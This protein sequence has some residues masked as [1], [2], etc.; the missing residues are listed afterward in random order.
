MATP[1]EFNVSKSGAATYTIPIQIPPGTAGMEPKLSLAY[2]SQSGNG[3]LGVGWSLAGLSTITRCPQTIAQDGLSRAVRYVPDDRFCLDGQRLIAIS[4]AYGANGTEYRTERDSFAKIVSFGS[5]GSGPASFT[6]WTKSGQVMDYGATDDSR[7]EAQGKA[8]VKVWAL[9]KVRDTKGNYFTVSYVEDNANGNYYPQSINYTGNTAAGVAPVNSVQFQYEGRPDIFP[10][11]QAG[12]LAQMT[13]RM[14]R[15]VTYANGVRVKDYVLSYESS[16]AASPSQGSR[17]TK[18]QECL[19]APSTTCFNSIDLAWDAA[20]SQLF[21][22]ATQNVGWGFGSP[23]S[24]G[25]TLVVGDFNGDGKSD[26]AYI[27]G[28]PSNAHVALSN[29]DGTFTTVQ[30]DMG[31]GFGT[32]PS[33]GFT[34]VVGDFNGDGKTDWAFVGGSPSNVHVALSNGDGTFTKVQQSLGWGFGTP[35]SAQFTLVA[36]DFNG[37][38]KT[39]FAFIG[40]NPSNAHVAL[41]NGDGTFTT[42]Q[43][44]MGWSF[45]APP[46][47]GYTLVVGDFN[48]DGKT[49]WAFVGGSPSNV[50]VALSNGDGTFTKV[51]QSL[52][53]GF[54]TPPSAQFTLV[55]GDFNGDGKTDFAFIGASPS[56]AH[57]AISTGD[58][59]FR[60]S[61]QQLFG[62]S[63][64]SP[65]SA[66]FD[67][68]TGDFNG[69]GKTDFAFVGASPTSKA[70][71]ILSAGNGAFRSGGEQLLLGWYFGT[72]PSKTYDLVTGDFNGDGKNDFLYISGSTVY[73]SLSTGGSDRLQQ[74][75]RN[76][77]GADVS[78]SYK[79]LTDSTVYTKDTNASR[80]VVDLQIP[81]YVVSSVAS[82]NGIGGTLTTNY[83]YGG[84]K[85]EAGTGR[86][87]LGFR[88]MRAT[89][90]DTG[91]ATYT[92]YR[93]DWPYTGMPALLKK[94]LPGSGN[95]GVLSQVSNSFGCL[96]PTDGSNCVVLPGRRYFPYVSPSTASS[97]DLSGA[98]LPTITT[99][100]QYDVWGNAIQITV[101]TSDGFSKTTTNSYLPADTSN[102]ILGRLSRATVNSTAP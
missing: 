35:P 78:I 82:G 18:L 91:I 47:A 19:P 79:P 48:G 93:Q 99:A 52:G 65:P 31:W 37:D 80:P 95:G 23:P 17:I 4:G 58:G 87:L 32:P 49:D 51:Q 57:I 7:I 24:A 27:G 55:A 83:A 53:W 73:A 89:Q 72:P 9:N 28:S 64:G 59:L 15:I 34:L 71:I 96:N 6:V 84:L 45:G 76:G 46:S 61:E 101:S 62:W 63:F 66:G 94:M 26:W 22:F 10:G 25:F 38:G 3:L 42:V 92:E 41:S 13:V 40:G 54:G 12:S 70:H 102:W 5:A 33:A 50:H 39:D 14:M 21:T 2:S 68:V 69:D 16:V 1:A 97:W 20:T 77:T 29:G 8:E 60:T 30:Q 43:Q 100:S 67:L 86:G 75:R 90:A 98:A 56:K 36:G 85:V 88:W 11:Y 74:I 81:M 44:D